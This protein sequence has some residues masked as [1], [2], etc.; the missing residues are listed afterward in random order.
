MTERAFGIADPR[1]ARTRIVYALIAGAVAWLL[2]PSSWGPT[3]RALFGGD[4][5]GALQL[6]VVAWIIF[7]SDTAETKR[8]A[9]AEDPGRH[10]VWILVLVICA[11][12]MASATFLLR[13]AKSEDKALVLVLVIAATMLAWSLSHAAFTLRYA[14]LYYR[15]PD[16]VGGLEFPNE[17]DEEPDDL[18]FAY[19]AFTIGM[20][21]QVSDVQVKD[22]HLRRTVLAHSLIS[23]G[24]NTGI[25]AL[26]INVVVSLVS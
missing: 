12:T 23:F 3:T 14:H 13:S 5:A 10:W 18:D 2:A 9:A 17:N 15:D 20:T 24:F 25:I 6:G 22:K 16:D 8:R 4:V 19:F 11:A 26:V 1:G 7:T 21:F